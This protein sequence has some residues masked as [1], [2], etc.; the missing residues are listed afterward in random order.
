V[1]GFGYRL[2][3]GPG[4]LFE[5]RFERELVDEQRQLV[6]RQYLEWLRRDLVER[7]HVQRFLERW[8]QRQYFRR[9]LE[10]EHFGRQ[11][12]QRWLVRW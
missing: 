9:K 2:D 8:L 1:W 11:L 12:L 7:R 5:R 3:L 10:R 4:R 6:E